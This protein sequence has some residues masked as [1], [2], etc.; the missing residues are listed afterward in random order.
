M[1]PA[2]AV[3]RASSAARR[4]GSWRHAS[5]EVPIAEEQLVR[6]LAGEHHAKA[7]GPHRLV[8]EVLGGQVPVDRQASLATTARG[9]ASTRRAGV[10]GTSSWRAPTWAAMRAARAGFVIVRIDEAQRKRAGGGARGRRQAQHGRRVEPAGQLHGHRDLGHEAPPH[11][12][13][14]SPRAPPARPR[15][16][17]QSA[18]KT[19]RPT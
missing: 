18:P 6:A 3:L 15:R 5:P 4:A 1:M 11:Q 2:E 16:A 17:P 19:R 14:T 9:Q 7:R 12:P 13:P 10:M 8:Q